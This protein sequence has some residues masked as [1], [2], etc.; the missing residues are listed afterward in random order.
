M[1]ILYYGP[2]T[3]IGLPSKGGYEAANRKIIDKLREKSIQV[4]EF[5][6]PQIN[7]RLG[8]IGKLAYIK[9]FFTPLCLFKYLGNKNIIIHTTPL[10]GNLLLPSLFL[11]FIANILKIHC[12]VDI[13]AGSLIHY[14]KTKGKYKQFL[15]KCMIKYADRITVEGFSYIRDIKEIMKL[16]VTID[17]LPN[18]AL[19]TDIKYTEREFSKINIFYF[20]RITL[21]K[22]IDILLNMMDFLDNNYH[23]YLAGPISNDIKCEDLSSDKITYLGVLTPQQLNETMKKMHFFVFPSKHIG[24]GQSNA[25]IEAMANGLV[26]ITSNQGFNAEVVKDCG[27]ILNNYAT[28]K[29]YAEKILSINSNRWKGLSIKSRNHIFK[30]HNIDIE[31]NKLIDIYKQ[32]LINE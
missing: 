16:D 17:Y 23:L 22:G 11:I 14:Y 15:L 6:N 5:A 24:E 10:Y 28:G 31:I 19:C 12:L 32:L 13:R 29:D 9:L 20:G 1:K 21:S 30:Y 26:P 3:P 25:L 2:I 27:V 18:V 8:F 7:K 4:I